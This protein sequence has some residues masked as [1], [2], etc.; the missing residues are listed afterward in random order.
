M[1]VLMKKSWRDSGPI[2]FAFVGI[3]GYLKSSAANAGN[4]NL[5]LKIMLVKIIDDRNSRNRIMPDKANYRLGPVHCSPAQLNQRSISLRR[6][7]AKTY[8]LSDISNFHDQ[9]VKHGDMECF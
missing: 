9:M 7:I 1:P 3:S 2:T 6:R 4:F 5:I 8:Y